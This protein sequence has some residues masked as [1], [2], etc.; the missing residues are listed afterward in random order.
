MRLNRLELLNVRSSLS[1][2]VLIQQEILL[3][4]EVN[5]S[6]GLGLLLLN[7]LKSWITSTNK[8]SHAMMLRNRACRRVPHRRIN[9]P[10]RSGPIAEVPIRIHGRDEQVTGL[11]MGKQFYN[12]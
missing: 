6:L 5:L 10:L 4:E 11:K 2:D 9:L 1:G 12:R 3:L 8:T 7:R